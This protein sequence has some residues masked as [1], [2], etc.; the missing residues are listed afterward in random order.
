MVL[1]LCSCISHQTPLEKENEQVFTEEYG[2][3]LLV[4]TEHYDYGASF[5]LYNNGKLI[6]EL[7]NINNYKIVDHDRYI[8]EFTQNEMIEFIEYL[9]IQEYLYSLNSEIIIFDSSSVLYGPPTEALKVALAG[10]HVR[11]LSLYLNITEEKRMIVYG[12]IE[13][14]RNMENVNETS[15]LLLSPIIQLYD[16]LKSYQYK[17]VAKWVPPQIEILFWPYNSAPNTRQW[18]E[19]FPDLNSPSSIDHG[20]GSY[21]VFIE[22]DKYDS[23]FNYFEG[24]GLEAV[25]INGKKMS[26]SYKIPFPNIRE[27]NLARW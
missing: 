5:V 20:D 18:I 27:L 16:K 7:N 9:S 25:E 12:D 22:F 14:I 6:Y 1:Y 10:S 17:N 11:F 2:R 24:R 19:G 21:S 23:F 4:L 3:P 15:F 26:I 8:I 13:T